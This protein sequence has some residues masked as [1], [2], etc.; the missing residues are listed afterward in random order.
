MSEHDRLSLE[1]WALRKLIEQLFYSEPEELE[2]DGRPLIEHWREEVGEALNLV[3][4]YFPK[5]DRSDQH[6]SRT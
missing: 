2:V 5:R 1:N 3:I 6:A 4:P